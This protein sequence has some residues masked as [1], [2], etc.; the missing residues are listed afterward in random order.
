MGSADRQNRATE[1]EGGFGC[2]WLRWELH[3]EARR[4]PVG[5]QV[6][7]RASTCV[8]R[9]EDAGR[10]RKGGPLATG[11]SLTFTQRRGFEQGRDG[12]PL[13]FHKPMLPSTEDGR[14]QTPQRQAGRHGT[15][16]RCVSRADRT[17][18]RSDLAVREKKGHLHWLLKGWLALSKAA[19][20]WGF[21]LALG[22]PQNPKEGC[23]VRCGSPALCRCGLQVRE[24]EVTCSGD[25]CWPC[26]DTEPGALSTVKS[27]TVPRASGELGKLLS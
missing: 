12:T 22:I 17:I 11:R 7:G 25:R 14:E 6:P 20:E 16:V 19:Q 21:R 10:V 1:A 2:V 23:R 15:S 3:S 24:Q 26:V 27:K 8:A 4:H 9:T 18:G 5:V 13:G